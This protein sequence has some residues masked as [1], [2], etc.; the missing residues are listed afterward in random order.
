MAML[1]QNFKKNFMK[2]LDS[3]HAETDTRTVN[4]AGGENP[5]TT[6]RV[7]NNSRNGRSTDALTATCSKAR[8]TFNRQLTRFQNI[9]TKRECLIEAANVQYRDPI[10][11]YADLRTK[12]EQLTD[13]KRFCNEC[14][15]AGLEPKVV[16]Q[17]IV[18]EGMTIYRKVREKGVSEVLGNRVLL[19]KEPLI[20]A[21]MMPN[22][23]EAT[24]LEDSS[25][26]PF[27]RVA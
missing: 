22:I 3:H 20:T 6:K 18:F 8:G 11:C 14:S 7:A 16:A 27:T 24:K 1:P 19:F 21:E 5:M 23:T 17:H 4:A 26:Q 12:A 10:R 2:N 9:N 25:E 13:S 15:E